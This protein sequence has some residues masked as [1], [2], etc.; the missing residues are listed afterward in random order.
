MPG[1][2]SSNYRR[3]QPD[4]IDRVAE[5][6]AAAWQDDNIPMRQYELA[7]NP[8]LEKFR[9]HEAVA[10]FDALNRCLRRIPLRVLVSK[11]R[12]LDVGASGG[13]YSEVIRIAK[14]SDVVPTFKVDF[15]YTACDYSHAFKTLA[16]RLYPDIE[17]DVADALNLPYHDDTFDITLHGAVL[18]HTLQYEKAIAEAVRVSSKYIIFHR[19]PITPD[20]QPTAFFEKEAYGVRVFESH[21]NETELLNLFC[22]HGL[23][24]MFTTDVFRQADGFC[25]RTYLLEKQPGLNHIQ[26]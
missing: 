19:T 15:R 20:N 25:H 24:P 11:P 9:K 18:M 8:E 7:V 3:L 10:P 21:F 5:E 22:A 26:V 2:I 1:L 6:C 17:F 13:Y 16:G 12:L 23:R 4:E 14:Y